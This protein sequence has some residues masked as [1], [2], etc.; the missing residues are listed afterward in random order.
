MTAVAK[1]SA[2]TAVAIAAA[3]AA[4]LGAVDA[5]VADARRK[6]A[7]IFLLPNTPRHKATSA[8]T[9]PEAATTRAAHNRVALLNLASI[10]AQ[11]VRASVRPLLRR[12]QR[13]TKSYCRVSL[14]QNIATNPLLPPL[15][16]LR[17]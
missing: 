7:A 3:E 5:V 1:S 2:A 13:K 17:P 14:S 4:G 11:K 12:I 10:A 9:I 16:P 6:E 8:P 15:L